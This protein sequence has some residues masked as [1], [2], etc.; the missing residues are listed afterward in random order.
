MVSRFIRPIFSWSQDA[1]RVAPLA[2]AASAR[3][4]LMAA[5]GGAF[6][7]QHPQQQHS[8]QSAHMHQQQR[9]RWAGTAEF[10]G[11]EQAVSAGDLMGWQGGRL[12]VML[13]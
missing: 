12:D 11:S 6:Q 13:S 9:H 10:N 2:L 4:S 5:L 8:L 1:F 3:G 7:R